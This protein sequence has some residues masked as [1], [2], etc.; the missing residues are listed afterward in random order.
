[1]AAEKHSGLE[2]VQP[3]HNNNHVVSEK[4]AAIA[5]SDIE[6][7]QL[8]NRGVDFEDLPDPDAGKSDEERARL[9]RPCDSDCLGTL[10]TYHRTRHSSG[11]WI[12]G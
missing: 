10:L 3:H 6:S 9:V 11:R 12:D 5:S 1:M 7:S 2:T 4:S 8:S